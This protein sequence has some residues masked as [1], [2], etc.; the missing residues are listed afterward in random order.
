MGNV[1]GARVFTQATAGA[2]G[3]S[4]IPG[5]LHHGGDKAAARALGALDLGIG[6][7][8]DV[9]VMGRR[10]HFGRADATRAIQGREDLGERDHL[11]ADTWLALDDEDL[12]AL[13]GHVDGHLQAGDAATDHQSIVFLDGHDA[14]A[15]SSFICRTSLRNG[16]EQ[17]VQIAHSRSRPIAIPLSFIST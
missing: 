16:L 8:R 13:V 15:R 12:K 14:S 5:F 9:V 2:I 6:H 3:L 4:Y 11:A 10:S 17:T 7:D 1:H